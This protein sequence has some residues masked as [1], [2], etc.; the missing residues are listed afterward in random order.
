MRLLTFK[1]VTLFVVLLEMC[2]VCDFIYEKAVIKWNRSLSGDLRYASPLPRVLSLRE[3]CFL[4]AKLASQLALVS[5]MDR[6]SGLV[7][8]VSLNLNFPAF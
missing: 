2:K 8:S 7:S 5:C 6:V 1:L 4:P 3:H